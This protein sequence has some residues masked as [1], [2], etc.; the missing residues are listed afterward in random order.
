MEIGDVR[1]DEAPLLHA[2]SLWAWVSISTPPARR[3]VTC[4]DS[5]EQVLRAEYG[6]V[7]ATLVHD[8]RDLELAEDALHDA[9]E[10]A[11]EAWPRT[12]TP[13][14][15]GAWLTVAGR[16]K[17]IDRLRRERRLGELTESLDV[18]D[19]PAEDEEIPD[20]R[21]R[22]LFACCHPSLTPEAQV[23][24]TLR[25]V[26]GLTTPEI[27]RA[28]LVP[29]ETLAQRLVRAKRQLRDAEVE[30]EVPDAASLPDRLASV[31]AVIYL[32][33]NEGYSAT[34][35]DDLTR[36]DLMA[37]AI[38]LGGI[39]A[40]LMP[41]EPEALGLEA[42][43][44]LHASRANARVSPAGQLVLLEDQD[45]SRWDADLIRRGLALLDR[46]LSYRAPGPY[47]LQ[48]AVAALHAQA[49]TADATDWPQIAALYGE[50]ARVQPSPVVELNRAVAVTMAEGPEAGL[51]LLDGLPLERYHLFHAARADL[52]RRLGADEEAAEAYRRAL[53]LT[54]NERERAFLAGRLAEV[55]R[56]S[57]PQ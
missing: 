8:F 40:T 13:R 10:V 2:E 22:L 56:P 39:V 37:E 7:L 48:A 15:A 46:A 43:M 34:A 50:L 53:D 23:A 18:D 57:L 35:G 1:D 9:I 27:A 55:V 32:V 51:A 3:K 31:L 26:G 17:A 4:V 36:P 42:L 20:E 38:R 12:G 24:L 41:D 45:R 6:R 11:L 29:E 28:F 52:L 16:R 44:L 33:F 5:L 54:A 21:L 25:L 49:A 30:F 47:Q 19:Q 14:N